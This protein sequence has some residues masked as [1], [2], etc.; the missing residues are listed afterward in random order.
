MKLPRVRPKG[1]AFVLA[2][3][4]AFGEERVAGM[5]REVRQKRI[6]GHFAPVFG[7]TLGVLGIERESALQLFM[8]ISVR[9]WVSAAVRLGIVGPLEGQRVQW[10]VARAGL[11]ACTING[12]RESPDATPS[13]PA[14]GQSPIPLAS[15]GV[16]VEGKEGKEGKERQAVQTAPVLDLIQGM[17]DR[18]YSRLFQS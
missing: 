16:P 7:A 11:E 12:A 6:V 10:R 3:S 4:K 14:R 18:L 13:L 5:L 17:Q 9:G 1:Q 15:P 8:F 2:C